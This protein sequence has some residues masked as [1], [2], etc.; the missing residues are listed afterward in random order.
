MEYQ[1]DRTR[2]TP[3][4]KLDLIIQYDRQKAV[5]P[6]LTQKEFCSVR[7]SLKHGTFGKWLPVMEGKR[8]E[9][10]ARNPQLQWSRWSSNGTQD[11]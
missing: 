1:A 10:D 4:Q 7:A 11:F 2:Y 9:I 3:Q 6:G 8:I 5:N